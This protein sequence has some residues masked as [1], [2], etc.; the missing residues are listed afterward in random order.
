MAERWYYYSGNKVVPIPIGNGEV[1]AVRPHSYVCIDGSFPAVAR[2]IKQ[3][4]LRLVGKP[5]HLQKVE[6][7]PIEENKG[8]QEPVTKFAKAVV[9]TGSAKRVGG[10]IVASAPATATDEEEAPTKKAPS[11]RK[12]RVTARKKKE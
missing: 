11:K 2:L 4:K 8:P 6:R 9:D 3:K 5:K 1:E 7:A 12:T 10:A